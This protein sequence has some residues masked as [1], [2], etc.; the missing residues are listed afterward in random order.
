MTDA[1]LV[2][3]AH[4]EGNVSNS[5]VKILVVDDFEMV[6]M[7]LINALNDLGFYQIEEAEHGVM[8]LDMLKAS[9]AA[10][11]PFSIVFCDWTMPEMTGI[12]VLENCRKN[13]DLKLLPFVMVTAESE[14]ESI[15]RAIKAGATDYLI[16]PISPELLEKKVYKILS[17]LS[18]SA[19]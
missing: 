12:E 13:E 19:A 10:G 3:E 15:V 14:Q 16:K 9:H 6:R 1:Y 8:A 4:P 7:M 2:V 5:K 17:K 11:H 18:S